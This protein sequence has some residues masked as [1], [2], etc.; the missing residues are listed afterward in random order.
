M[1]VYVCLSTQVRN[2]DAIKALDAQAQGEALIR[3]ALAELKMWGFQREFALT[4]TSQQAKDQV[5]ARVYTHVY[6]IPPFPFLLRSY[7]Y[8]APRY[9]SPRS[10]SA[11]VVSVST[12]VGACVYVSG[13]R[14]RWF[15]ACN[16]H[17]RV[18]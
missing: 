8:V 1:S 11:S 13:W 2:A 14:S 17:Q 3:K 7:T 18:A 10:Q 6:T 4:D 12:C 15:Q 5:C 16:A 9:D